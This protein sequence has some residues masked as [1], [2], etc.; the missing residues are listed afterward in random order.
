MIFRETGLAGAFLVDVERIEDHRGFFARVWCREEFVS[1]GLVPE[2]VQA[3]MGYS[4][5]GGTLRGLH[6]QIHPHEEVKLLRCTRGA[7]HDVL[8]DLREESPT[9]MHWEGFDLT[10]ENRKM[11]YVPEGFAH[12]YLTLS[13]HTEIHYQTSRFYSPRHARGIR[14]DD[15]AFN[16]KWPGP[17]DIVSDADRNWP[18]YIPANGK[19]R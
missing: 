12:G 5:K 1:R 11:V 18:D 9:Y 7:V 6:F 4:R 15:P 13:D 8:V 14:F 16:I 2:M 19:N 3:N 17:V 10:E